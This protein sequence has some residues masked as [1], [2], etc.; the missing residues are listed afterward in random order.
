VV[1]K[2]AEVAQAPVRTALNVAEAAIAKTTE[3]EAEAI[4]PRSVD[5]EIAVVVLMATTDVEAAVRGGVAL[6]GGWVG[7]HH[8][9]ALALKYSVVRSACHS[10]CICTSCRFSFSFVL[11]IWTFKITNHFKKNSNL[12]NCNTRF[13]LKR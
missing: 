13:V 5:E 2:K 9:C 12:E 4:R 6:V 1:V 3:A 10:V 7:S 11:Q 8:F